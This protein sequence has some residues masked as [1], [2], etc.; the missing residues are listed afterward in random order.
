MATSRPP[1]PRSYVLSTAVISILTAVATTVGLFVP[2]FYRDAPVLLPQMYGQDL[3]TLVV[4]LPALVLSLYFATRGS[5]RG[6]IVWLGVIGYLLYTYASYSFMTAFNE[7]Y[8]IYTT[9]LWL[10]LF[11]F[12]GGMVRLDATAL[13]R[14]VGRR[15]DRAYVA[16]HLLLGVLIA[17]LWL[18]EIFPAIRSGTIP[19]SIVE[20]GLPTSVIYAFDL[21][22]IV[23]AFVLTAYWLRVG[24]PYGYAFTAVLLV[25]IAT[26][27]GAVLAMAVFMIRDGQAVPAPQIVIF[28]ALTLG[29]VVLMVRF[30]RSIPSDSSPVSNT[31]TGDE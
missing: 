28:G 7:L 23:P 21:G 29:S 31:L 1:V 5:L 3:L 20:A 16:F 30:L 22:I 25:K 27:G 13:K 11:T 14:S 8:L 6:Y 18:S 19:P 2:G 26:L 12:V 15:S 24:R 17:F 10:T 9:L 4:A